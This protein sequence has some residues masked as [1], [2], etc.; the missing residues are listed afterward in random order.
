MLHSGLLL[1]NR[2]SEFS[3]VT[4]LKANEK[5][6]VAAEHVR[7]PPQSTDKH[8]TGRL[9]YNIS[10]CCAYGSGGE[11]SPSCH[12]LEISEMNT[13]ESAVTL[14]NFVFVGL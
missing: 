2:R 8:F 7:A 3:V 10:Q 5:L 9:S 4:C 14:L 13:L 6:N 12:W 11:L 1:L